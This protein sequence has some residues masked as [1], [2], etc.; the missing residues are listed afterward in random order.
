MI[1]ILFAA[2][3]V[4]TPVAAAAQTAPAAAPAPMPKFTRVAGVVSAMTADKITVTDKDGKAATYALSPQWYVVTTQTVDI[5]A[6]K[7]GSFIASANMDQPSGE[8]EALEMR[9]FE[10]GSTLGAGNYPMDAPKKMMTNATV[11]SVSKGANGR[12]LTV[13][14]P[15]R[16]EYPAG[17]KKIVVPP[18]IPV[19]ASIPADKAV[20][21]PGVTIMALAVPGDDGA[22]EVTRISIPAAKP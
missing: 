15:A 22:P 13:T 5:D 8:G 14:Y 3:L 19:I 11:S 7:P 6:I 17:T 2:A 10:P 9:M 16:G 1:R 12:E 18:G 4:A 20:V 21:K